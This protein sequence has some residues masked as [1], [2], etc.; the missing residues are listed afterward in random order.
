MSLPRQSAS[1]LHPTIAP[2]AFEIEEGLFSSSAQDTI[3]ASFAPQHY[4]SG[5]SYP[6][7]VWLHGPGCDER[8]LLR[9]MPQ[10]S[11][12][13]YVA[14]APRGLLVSGES[15]QNSTGM[16]G[17][18]A[19]HTSS[20]ARPRTEAPESSNTSARIPRPRV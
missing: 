20:P 8:Q 18:G 14:I 15:F 10:I 5:Y 17:N 3:H 2:A 19:V 6:L 4:E 12:R 7:L 1:L 13:N 9:I 16:L 11:M